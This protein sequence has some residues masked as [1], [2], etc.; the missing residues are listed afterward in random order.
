[1]F[2]AKIERDEL[3][4]RMSRREPHRSSGK[5]PVLA[6][7]RRHIQTDARVNGRPVTNRRR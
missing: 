4:I 7:A 6:C 3:V 5:T 2:E 1:M